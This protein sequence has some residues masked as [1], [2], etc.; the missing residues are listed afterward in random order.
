MKKNVF[1]KKWL[2]TMG[3]ICTKNEAVVLDRALNHRIVGEC[4]TKTLCL[5][6]QQFVKMQSAIEENDYEL[7]VRVT[8]KIGHLQVFLD[9]TRNILTPRQQEFAY[10][11]LNPLHK[12][13]FHHKIEFIKKFIE[14]RVDIYRLDDKGRSPLE[15]LLRSWDKQYIGI[16]ERIIREN[17]SMSGDELQKMFENEY[18]SVKRNSMDCFKLLI[19]A[20]DDLSLKFGNDRITALHISLEMN[21]PEVV[22]YLISHGADIESRT[23]L[24]DTPLLLAAKHF[25]IWSMVAL[26]ERGANVNARNNS[27]M[28]ALHYS[29]MSIHRS[30]HAI[31]LLVKYG[32][33]VNARTESKYTPLHHAALAEEYAKVHKLLHYD[34]DP[35]FETCEGK[36]VLFFLMDNRSGPNPSAAIAYNHALCEMKRIQIRDYFDDLPI[37]LQTGYPGLAERFDDV[38]S[39]PRPLKQLALIRVKRMLGKRRQSP[40]HLRQLKLPREIC[41]LIQNGD[42]NNDILTHL[43]IRIQSQGTQIYSGEDALDF[44]LSLRLGYGLRWANLDMS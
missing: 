18:K 41:Q 30:K 40:W 12:A 11:L 42:E 25:N 14:N 39:K 20:Y 43:G 26:L 7:F 13:C 33:D 37:N 22:E 21:I 9:D 32:A 3:A 35:D 29:C 23:R 2:R 1:F 4:K 27:G 31:D 16:G 38:T 8:S 17:Q 28:T 44:P 5:R 34:A 36:T 15:V 10:L 6:L 19:N 24:G